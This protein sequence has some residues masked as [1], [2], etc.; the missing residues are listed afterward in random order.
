[1]YLSFAAQVWRVQ[2]VVLCKTSANRIFPVKQNL[3]RVFLIKQNISDCFL[4]HLIRAFL[5]QQLFCWNFTIN[6]LTKQ[7][8]YPILAYGIRVQVLLTAEVFLASSITFLVISQNFLNATKFTVVLYTIPE[9]E[10]ISTKEGNG[11]KQTRE[12]TWALEICRKLVDLRDRSRRK[13]L[14]ILGRY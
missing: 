5:S 2:S 7:W 13:N 6:C 3:S 1:M 12:P 10:L 8:W 9:K 14:R 4:V 11:V